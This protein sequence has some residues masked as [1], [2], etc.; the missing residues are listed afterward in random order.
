[1][2]KT[3]FYS[4]GHFFGL[5]VGLKAINFL[6]KLW[7]GYQDR[8]LYRKEVQ[9]RLLRQSVLK[10]ERQPER[11]HWTDRFL[12]YAAGF[13]VVPVLSGSSSWKFV[14]PLVFLLGLLAYLP[15]MAKNHFNEELG[16]VSDSIHALSIGDQIPDLKIS[17]YQDGVF[18]SVSLADYKGK[19]L[20]IDFWATWCGSCISKF[21]EDEGLQDDF[22]GR[23]LFMM[24]NSTDTADS[25]G[26]AQ[27]FLAGWQKT[28]QIQLSSPMVF[29]D[30]LLNKYFPRT[31]LPHYVWIDA[32]G[33]VRAITRKESVIRE[34]IMKAINDDQ[35]DLP[36]K[37][38]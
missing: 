35:F 9:R 10:R 36:L 38:F 5:L 15:V 13:T 2:I 4:V 37:T 23:L 24:V 31:A 1:M 7:V 22:N 11:G 29:E 18:K 33:V 6:K 32:K 20:I 34:N 16:L 27:R 14:F 17:V 30:Q 26:N 12:S 19:L 21:V 28:H 25:L 3:I 8:Q